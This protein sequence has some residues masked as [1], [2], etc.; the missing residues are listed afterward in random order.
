MNLAQS[1]AALMLEKARREILPR[2]RSWIVEGVPE[3][4]P[5][6]GETVVLCRCACKR[7]VR[8]IPVT[9]LTRGETGQCVLCTRE[10]CRAGMGHRR[11]P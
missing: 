5:R 10:I 11:R 8:K 6:T 2:Y 7:T 4:N 1:R 9:D 3:R